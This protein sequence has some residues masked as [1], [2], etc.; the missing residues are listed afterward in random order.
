MVMWWMRASGLTPSCLRPFSLTTITP[1]APSQIWLAD[2]AVSLPFSA[3]SL[4]PLMPSSV[5]SKRMP[6][7]M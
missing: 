3:I 7:S 5:A 6:S 4:T 2:A 1:D